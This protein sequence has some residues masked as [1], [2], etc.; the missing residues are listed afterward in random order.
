MVDWGAIANAVSNAGTG[1]LN[2]KQAGLDRDVSQSQFNILQNQSNTAHQREMADLQAAGLNPILTASGGAGGGNPIGSPVGV[3]TPSMGSGLSDAISSAFNVMKVRKEM[4]L[5]DAQTE[6]TKQDASTAG[7][8][9]Y[10]YTQEG[11]NADPDSAVTRSGV[12]RDVEAAK[13]AITSQMVG[14]QTARRTAAETGKISAETPGVRASSSIRESEVKA[15]RLDEEISRMP[16]D[17]FRRFISR[18]LPYGS[19]A[20]SIRH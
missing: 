10:K 18:W 19:S 9:E 11:R 12:A 3:S 13:S 5:L 2:Y 6:R 15:A 8:L 16:P 14:R 4:D 1:Y 17:Q 7:A 20:Q